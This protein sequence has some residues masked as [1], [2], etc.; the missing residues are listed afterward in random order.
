MNPTVRALAVAGAIIV[1]TGAC[2]GSFSFTIGGKSP[3]VAAA[4]LIEGDLA[5]QLGMAL[6][7]SCDELEDPK[8][9]DSFACTGA[10]D[11]GRIIDFNIDIGEDEV[12]ADSLNLLVAERVPALEQSVIDALSTESNL[13]IPAGSLDC[14][15]GPIIVPP[16]KSFLCRLRDVATDQVF[17]TTV[18]ITD[19]ATWTFDVNVAA[20]PS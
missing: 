18:T 9:G 6:A 2:S 15:D 13:N 7:A 10:T 5:D 17:D 20:E 3:E 11:D 1:V 14:G 4:D 12:L 19:Q 8:E 16:D